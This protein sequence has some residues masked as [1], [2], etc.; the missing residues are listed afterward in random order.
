MAKREK[1]Q[2]EETG[3]GAP[4]W[5][6]T[7]GDLMSLLLTFFIL[8]MTFSSIELTKFKAAMGSLQ[9]ALGVLETDRGRVTY[10][11]EFVAYRKN[12]LSQTLGE[13]ELYL[14]RNQ[15][16]GLVY[17]TQVKE[18]IRFRLSDPLLFDSGKADLRPVGYGVLSRIA[19]IILK[20]PCEVI[21]E[22]HTDNVPIHTSQFPS[23][24]ELSAARAVSVVKYLALSE[25]I[26]PSRLSA[27]GYGEHRPLVP[28][29]TLEN[30]AKNRR[31][32]VFIRWV[33]DGTGDKDWTE[34]P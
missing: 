3:G 34:Q 24:W 9:G 12:V 1:R 30:R 4:G 28:N 18:G 11:E 10:M 2:E 27:V 19:D 31:V 32:E 8:L 21:V 7:Y 25:G 23:N 5:M 33:E 15:L 26:S 14:K 20:L 16:Q 17:V 22:G 29:T 6:T 13:I